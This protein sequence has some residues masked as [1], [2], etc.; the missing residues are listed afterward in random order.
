[1][2]ESALNGGEKSF[3]EVWNNDRFQAARA[4][5]KRE[6]LSADAPVVAC[7]NCPVALHYRNWDAHVAAGGG[8]NDFVPEHDGWEGIQYFLRRVPAGGEPL[9]EL[10]RSP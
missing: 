4:V 7:T 5:F 10:R 6:P 9:V 2:A 1:M 3:R 8:V